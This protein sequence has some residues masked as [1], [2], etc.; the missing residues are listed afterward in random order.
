MIYRIPTED[1]Y[2]PIVDEVTGEFR[3]DLK[4]ILGKPDGYSLAPAHGRVRAGQGECPECK[5]YAG[6]CPRCHR[7]RPRPGE[8]S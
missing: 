4:R 6:K 8:A 2:Q 5:N 1:D 3:K 7:P